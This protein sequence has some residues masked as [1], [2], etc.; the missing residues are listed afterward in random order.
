MTDAIVEVTSAIKR[1]LQQIDVVSQNIANVNTAG[2]KAKR[3]SGS[4]FDSFMRT[5]RSVSKQQLE[6]SVDNKQGILRSSGNASDLAI[7]GAEYFVVMDPDTSNQYLRR[8]LKLRS[9]AEGYLVDHDGFRVLGANGNIMIDEEI[10]LITEEGKLF[11][12]GDLSDQLLLVRPL[13]SALNVANSQQLPLAEY[14]SEV[15]DASSVRQGF[16]EQSNV[17]SSE[18]MVKLMQLS[19]HIESSQRALVSIDQMLGSG[20]NQIGNR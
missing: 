1:D 17:N 14:N 15:V 9:D 7:L 6:I 8:S 12:E 20:I 3:L 10:P 2:Y 13:S 11:Q 19:K 5:D 4:S 18:Q 16:I